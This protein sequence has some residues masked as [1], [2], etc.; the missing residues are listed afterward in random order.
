VPRALAGLDQR[1][2]PR[3]GALLVHL[4]AV[5]GHVERHVRHVQEVVR[6]VFLDQVALVPEA[7]DEL[8]HAVRRVDLHDVPEH[9]LAADLDHGL[10]PE[11][12]FLAD[13][14]AHAP[15]QD[16]ALHRFLIPQ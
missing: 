16:H 3:L 6:E 14:G 7:D 10:G 2:L 8:V 1:H 4:H 12:R 11:H 9:R 13:A 5:V 15:G